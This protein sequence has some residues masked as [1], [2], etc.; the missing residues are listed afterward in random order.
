[1]KEKKGGGMPAFNK[2]HWERKPN[3]T[4]VANGKYASEMGA[5]EELKSQVD[6]LAN[7][8]KKNKQKY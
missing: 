5:I 1:M 2:D 7:Y 6:G 8:A 4:T 3:G